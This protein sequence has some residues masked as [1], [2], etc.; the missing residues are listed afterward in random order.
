MS[1]MVFHFNNKNYENVE[2]FVMSGRGCATSRPN[3]Y[4][5][6]RNDEKINQQNL[7]F[8]AT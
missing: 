5:I 2:D 1:K 7:D 4:Q 3:H 8:E 6:R